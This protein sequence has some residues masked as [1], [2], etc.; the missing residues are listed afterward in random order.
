MVKT[1]FQEFEEVSAKQ[2]K[3]KIQFDLKG[4]DYNEKLVHQS[5]DGINIKPFYN[6]ED[7]DENLSPSFP[8][9]WNICEKIYVNSTEA[10]NKKAKHALAK[11]A[12]SLWFEIPSEEIDLEKLLEGIILKNIPVYLKPEFLSENFFKGLRE[13]S[14]EKNHQIYLQTDIIGK[15][16]RSGNWFYSLKED[17]RILEEI[18]QH[19]AD[20]PSLVSVNSALYQ[21][22]GANIPQQLAYSLGHINEYLNFIDQ[23]P[24]NEQ[25][26]RVFLPQF[27]VASGPNYFFEIAK[28]KA[29][30]WLYSCI[31]EEYKVSKTCYILAHPSRRN[32]TLYDYNVNLLRTTTES[33]S[34]VLGGADAV[35]NSPYDAIYHKTNEF[36]DRIARNQLLILKHEAYLNKVVNAA[37]GAYYIENLTKEFSEKALAIFKEIE[38]GGGFLK[39]LKEGLIQKKIKESAKKEQKEFEEGKL[40]L[41]GTNKYVNPEDRMKEEI[42]L[43]PFLK[44]NP[45]KTLLEPILERRLAEKN[46][47]QRLE[48]E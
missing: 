12:E 47:Q 46:E 23:L 3:Q 36:G 34:A 32:K 5:L 35:N 28:I 40:V 8:G 9:Q 42:E 39:Q 16:A 43:F 37:Q 48:Q 10:A 22:A 21:N 7:V 26:K 15:L 38:A 20:S 14:A 31:A 41:V 1:L 25:I 30:R 2:W 4:A 27:I 24:E 19:S 45:R 33:M 13:F 18:L 44:K 6:A 29:L 11:G 17:H